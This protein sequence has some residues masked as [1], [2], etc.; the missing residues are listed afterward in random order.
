MNDLIFR[1]SRFYLETLSWLSFKLVNV[2]QTSAALDWLSPFNIQYLTL[3]E[4]EPLDTITNVAI[5]PWIR[6][7]NWGSSWAT[8]RF[9]RRSVQTIIYPLSSLVGECSLLQ[10]LTSSWNSDGC[11]LTAGRLGMVHLSVPT[12]NCLCLYQW[13]ELW[14]FRFGHVQ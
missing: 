12:F 10:W 7:S 4:D 11:P 14:K 3:I 8:K 9:H 6:S 1:H 2:V 13:L 5:T